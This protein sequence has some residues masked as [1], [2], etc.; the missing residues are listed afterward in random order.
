MRFMNDPSIWIKELF[1][2]AGLSYSLSSLLSTVT[3]VVIV[4][5][6]SWLANFVAKLII[7]HIVTKIVKRTTSQWDDIF[8]EQKVFTRISHLAPALVI[9]FM[10]G[11]ALKAY[12]GWLIAVNKCKENHHAGNYHIDICHLWT[13]ISQP[14]YAFRAH[15]AINHITSAGA[16]CDILVN[17]LG[18]RKIS[19]H[20]D[21]STLYDLRD[22][23]C[24]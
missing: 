18:S 4:T 12:P 10:A 8:L 11:W 3:L 20:C 9:W 22:N 24:L 17:T 23:K 16:R 21:G 5:V 15:A 7:N 14:G 6:V 19:S 1:I 2:K 13:A